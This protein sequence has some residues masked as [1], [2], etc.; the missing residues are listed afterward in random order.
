MVAGPH[1]SVSPRR[2][3]ILLSSA[4]LFGVACAP[5]SGAEPPREAGPL[6]SPRSPSRATESPKAPEAPRSN[7]E[8]GSESPPTPDPVLRLENLLVTPEGPAPSE[9][10][11]EAR[12]L[13]ELEP[14]FRLVRTIEVGAGYLEDAILSEDGSKVAVA[15]ED[16]GLLSMFSVDDG[17]R[18]AQVRYPD[19]AQFDSL[20]LVATTGDGFL[21]G[22]KSGIFEG[23]FGE[24]DLRPFRSE[25]ADTLHYDTDTRLLTALDRRIEPQSGSGVLVRLS[26]DGRSEPSAT[27]SFLERPDGLAYAKD[28]R[29]LA[30]AYYPSN[31]VVLYDLES[32][33]TV[34]AFPAPEYSGAIALSKDG[35]FLAVG[36]A[37][38]WLYDTSTGEVLAR[39][40][41]YGNN[42]DTVVFSPDERLLVT[43][44][45]EGKARSYAIDLTTSSPKLG[46]PQILAHRGTANVYALHFTPDARRLVTSSG[47]KTIK[48]WERKTAP[49]TKKD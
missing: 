3:K 12:R 18:L 26:A 36:G 16:T 39:D 27:A 23:T 46:T 15:S 49:A 5:R 35:R 10:P 9:F 38:L 42:I 47:D 43:S 21:L 24:S 22:G 4:L 19:F 11:R 29:L 13:P 14:R 1:D 2:M 37:E 48:I 6:E 40:A 7:D 17:R 34:R 25:A 28:G 20:A 33:S 45:Y 32:G 8:S 41:K 30:V 44:A 31:R